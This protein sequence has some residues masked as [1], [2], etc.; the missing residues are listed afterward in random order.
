M[1]AI[2]RLVMTSAHAAAIVVSGP[3]GPMPGPDGGLEWG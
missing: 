1:N 3:A 2:V